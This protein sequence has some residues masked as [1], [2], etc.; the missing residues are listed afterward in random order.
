MFF[1]CIYILKI[2]VLTSILLIFTQGYEGVKP[3]WTRISFP[4]YMSREEFEFVLDAVKFVATYGHQFLTLYHFNWKNGD[5]TL[6]KEAYAKVFNNARHTIEVESKLASFM[7]RLKLRSKGPY[8]NKQ[9]K[10][11]DKTNINDTGFN[12]IQKYG[13]Y[14]K[15]A[16]FIASML[17]VVPEQCS[18]PENFD[19]ELPF[20]I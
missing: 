18:I 20:K 5:W 15:S 17:P 13:S 3:A 11:Q 6:K 1:N 4:Y 16:I 8:N 19:I 10:D 9:H 14:M 7:Q 2:L 12:L